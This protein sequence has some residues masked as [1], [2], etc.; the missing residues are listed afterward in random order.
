MLSGCNNLRG[1]K[2]RAFLLFPLALSCLTAVAAEAHLAWAPG[3]VRTPLSL[4][5]H[6]SGWG[7][8]DAEDAWAGLVVHPL[9]VVQFE[10]ALAGLVGA[11]LL[12]KLGTA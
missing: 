11:V 12:V 7:L 5:L 1:R 3:Q 10:L 9:E 4:G 8:Q 6:Q 2:T